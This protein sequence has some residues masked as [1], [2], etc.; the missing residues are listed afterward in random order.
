MGPIAG[1]VRAVVRPAGRRLRVG[2]ATRTAVRGSVGA[3]RFLTVA[4]RSIG[5]ET[6]Y[7]DVLDMAVDGDAVHVDRVDHL[8]RRNGS[9]IASAP[10]A[11]VLTFTEDQ[12]THWREY[13]DSTTFAGQALATTA[14]HLL[15]QAR[16]LASHRRP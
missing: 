9:L 15:R 7:V 11:G 2:P 12:V 1:G 8:R 4:R 6:C 13:F 14:T 5:L 10:V 16:N 3:R